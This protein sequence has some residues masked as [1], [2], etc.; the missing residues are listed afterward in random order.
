MKV[1]DKVTFKEMS[2][3]L[4]DNI[5]KTSRNASQIGIIFYVYKSDSIKN[6]ERIRRSTGQLQIRTVFASQKIN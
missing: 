2:Q 5:L 6:A 1:K 4:L 3:K